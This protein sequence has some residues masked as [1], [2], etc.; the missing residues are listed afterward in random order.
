VT[1]HTRLA[2]YGGLAVALGSFAM[3]PVIQGGE[4][5]VLAVM[6]IALI[7]GTGEVCRRSR[8]ARPLVPVAQFG[9]LVVFVTARFAGDAAILGL[10]PGPAA[11]ERLGEVAQAGMTDINK[12][13]APVPG[14]DGIVALA[15]A[16]IC[17]VALVVDLLAVTLRRAALAGL[18]L[19][20]LYSVAAAVV[21]N[22]VP[23][24]VFALAGFGYLGL[25]LTEGRDRVTQWGRPLRTLTTAAG[26]GGPGGRADDRRAAADLETSP[27]TQV[28]RRIGATA[29]GLAIVVPAL[30]P[31]VS[32]GLFGDGGSGFGNG[33]SRRIQTVN[34]MVTLRQDLNQPEN[35]TLA[36]VETNST[37]PSEQYL[38]TATLDKFDG[39]TWTPTKP[40][41]QDVPNPLPEPDG[42]SSDVPRKKVRTKIQIS[43][44]LKSQWLLLPQPATKVDVRGRWRFDP[45]GHDIIADG[46]QSTRGIS[47]TVNSVELSPTSEQLNADLSVPRTKAELTSV[48]ELPPLVE[49]LADE[50]VGDAQTS[51]E[52]AVN[53]QDWFVTNFE[54]SKTVQSG[55]NRSLIEQFLTN[56]VGYCEQ[57]AATMAV[58]ARLHGI[59]ARVA[60]GFT[61]GTRQSDGT[62][63]VKSHDSHAWPELFFEGVGWLRFEPTPTIAGTNGNGSVPSYAQPDEGGQGANTGDVTT[64]TPASSPTQATDCPTGNAQARQECEQAKEEAEQALPADGGSGG[65]SSFP[66]IPAVLAALVLLLLGTPWLARTTTRRRRLARADD[67]EQCVRG[68]WAEL[69]DTLRDY[70]YRWDPAETPRQMAA[71]VRGEAELNGAAADGL[72]RI[73]RAAERLRYARS[74][75]S[76]TDL[77]AN[78]DQ[79]RGGLTAGVSRGRRWRAA[80]LPPSTAGL[81][82]LAGERVADALDW[83][84]GLS[85]RLR[86]RLA[87]ARAARAASGS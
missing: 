12:Y 1:G 42:T 22:G 69:R 48:P 23:W 78:V 5:L 76:A 34:P 51:F 58:M 61:A 86:Q 64:D 20:A 45:N 19:L 53:L 63:V 74:H 4:W 68:A 21:K 29:L 26:G 80:L 37:R 28:G 2:L 36:V 41:L 7:V 33:G 32:Q 35:R 67:P 79:V 43:D 47:Y 59:P 71:R 14:T 18:P 87:S 66:T 72:A 3:L 39:D 49:Q 85:G 24:L 17:V 54:Y 50:A 40:R 38:R 82:S 73:A 11:I 77:F 55:H 83:V 46:K 57:F 9:M 16:G 84:D 13:A 30:I 25:L 15:V 8:I 75:G 27:L 70:G 44:T 81:L 56:R 52:K 10:V 62:Y 65:G 31:D 6:G 60:V